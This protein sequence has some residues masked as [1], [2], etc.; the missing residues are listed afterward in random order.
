MATEAAKKAK[1][2]ADRKMTV[3]AAAA[4]AAATAANLSARSPAQKSLE[5]SDIIKHPSDAI[6][7]EDSSL[8]AIYWEDVACTAAHV[9]NCI[10]STAIG[11]VHD[12]QP[13]HPSRSALV[14]K[15]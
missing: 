12:G 10:Y 11:D 15:A 13:H 3:A 9:K 6:Y 4:A 7:W 14:P 2:A 8:P 1:R 5:G